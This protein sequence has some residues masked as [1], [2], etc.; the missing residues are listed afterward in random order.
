MM[1]G[2]ELHDTVLI[3][4]SIVG[5]DLGVFS[6]KTTNTNLQNVDFHQVFIDVSITGVEIPWT[7]VAAGE[8]ISRADIPGH[9]LAYTSA[10]T[11]YWSGLETHLSAPIELQG[12]KVDSLG[13]TQISTPI[14]PF[15][16]NIYNL[17]GAVA[18][19]GYWSIG[20]GKHVT[21]IEEYVA[22]RVTG[23]LIKVGIVFELPPTIDPTSSHGGGYLRPPAYNGAYDPNNAAP[24]ANPDHAF[25]RAGERTVIDV[26]ANDVDPEG[27]PLKLSG[28]QSQY[29]FVV[30]NEDGTL[31]Y[32]A[33][34]GQSGQDTI[35]YW[36]EDD[37][38]NFT[39]GVLNVSVEI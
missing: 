15:M 12:S 4:A 19:N 20:G 34:P 37:Q 11:S 30:E 13:A 18:E 23:E 28:V 39:R 36:V 25:V 2:T 29:G 6:S 3:G 16:I 14:D 38:G 17:R 1:F 27:K 33:D 9:A 21:V 7:G 22:D 10:F 26:L 32:L 24:I 8:I 5:F 31:T 35:Y